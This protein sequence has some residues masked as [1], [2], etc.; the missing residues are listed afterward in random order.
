[1]KI[2]IEDYLSKE[3]IKEICT[4]EIKRHIRDVVGN[5]SVSSDR[6]SVLIGKLAKDLAKEG[7]Q[8]I[9]PN[10]KELINAQIQSEIGKITLA[11]MFWESYGWKST[12]NKVLVEVLNQNK[13]LLDAKMK[14][15]FNT[16]K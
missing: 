10:F 13:P 16:V 7:I 8:E 9:I 15:I 5:V 14:E 12:G 2:N 3:E 1:M 11:Q 4:E 6:E